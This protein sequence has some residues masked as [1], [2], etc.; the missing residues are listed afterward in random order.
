MSAGVEARLSHHT[1][2]GAYNNNIDHI[3]PFQGHSEK[4]LYDRGGIM[5][6]G[7]YLFGGKDINGVPKGH[8]GD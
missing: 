3:E 6:E 2:A 7:L 8:E 4:K 1:I 5:R